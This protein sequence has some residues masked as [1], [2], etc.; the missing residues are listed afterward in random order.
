MIEAEA[1]AMSRNINRR[2]SERAVSRP[3]YI[4]VACRLYDEDIESKSVSPSFT[5]RGQVKRQPGEWE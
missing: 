2:G 5:G 3:S 4:D 1:T